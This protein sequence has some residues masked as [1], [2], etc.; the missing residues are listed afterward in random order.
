[1]TTQ[2]FIIEQPTGNTIK[3]TSVLLTE[4]NIHQISTLKVYCKFNSSCTICVTTS[5]AC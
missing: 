1:M 3:Q 2:M 5:H 4:F